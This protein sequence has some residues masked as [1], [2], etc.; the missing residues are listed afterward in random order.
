M[1]HNALEQ[2]HRAGIKVVL[3]VLGGLPNETN[4]THQETL[5]FLEAS[6]DLVWLHN[7]YNFVP[8]PK[9]P[10]YPTIRS[11]IIDWDFN[12]WRED[13]PVVFTPYN[14]SREQS[15]EQFLNLVSCA[16]RLVEQ[17][18]ATNT[19]LSISNGLIGD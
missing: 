7:L 11:R 10:L 13:K 14:Q 8:Y 16:T 17:R 1:Y 12:N 19:A 5:S 2:L 6:A 15:W 3:N 4:A 18:V 9:T